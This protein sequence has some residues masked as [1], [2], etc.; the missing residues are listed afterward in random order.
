MENRKLD[1]YVKAG[2]YIV[3]YV[4]GVFLTRFGS[5]ITLSIGLGVIIGETI[6]LFKKLIEFINTKEKKT[7]IIIYSI[8]SVFF[9]ILFLVLFVFDTVEIKTKYNELNG[10][11]QY[12]VGTVSAISD[13]NIT[14]DCVINKNE[15]QFVCDELSG[16]ELNSEIILYFNPENLAS[17]SLI[18]PNVNKILYMCVYLFITIPTFFL[19]KTLITNLY[20]TFK[21]KKETNEVKVKK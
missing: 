7:K 4:I 5:V 14:V 20:Y 13:E 1:L 3:I 16:F 10:F 8:G 15:M 2:F 6:F 19:A 18:P 17:Y 9:G 21:P 11:T 12:V